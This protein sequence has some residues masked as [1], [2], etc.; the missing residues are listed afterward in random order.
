V[1]L[2]H[3]TKMAAEPVESPCQATSG[4][5]APE[6]RQPCH[7]GGDVRVPVAALAQLRTP[8]TDGHAVVQDRINIRARVP[9][10]GRWADERVGRN[11]PPDTADGFLDLLL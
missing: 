6:V 7:Q 3:Q 4:T 2:V 9:A 8:V 1:D 10:S 5:D 11:V